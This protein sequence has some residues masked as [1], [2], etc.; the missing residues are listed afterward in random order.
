MARMARVVA[1]GVPHHIT[2]RGDDRREVFLLAADRRYR[3]SGHLWQKRFYSCALGR[4]DLLAALAYVDLNAVRARLTERAGK[5]EW[6][7]AKAPVAGVASDALLDGWAGS[8]LRRASGAGLQFGD[9]GFVAELEARA[10]RE[11]RRRR[12]GPQPR[13]EAES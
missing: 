10:G 5:S 4:T 12:P 3:P 13:R 7:S 6:S 1:E 11:L 2:Q 9:D 8:E